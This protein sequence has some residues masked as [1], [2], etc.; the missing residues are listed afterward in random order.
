[1]TGSP[2]RR[3]IMVAV[4]FGVP[5][6]WQLY[7]FISALRHAPVFASL[8][9]GLGGPLPLVTRSFF[10]AYPFWWVLPVLFTALSF[11]VWRRDNP[12]LPYFVAVLVASTV[13]ALALHAW[14]NEAIFAPLFTILEKIG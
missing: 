1:M 8:F 4:V 13:S 6:V 14:L 10:A 11:D 7:A 3:K 12:P 9:A 2:D 5:I